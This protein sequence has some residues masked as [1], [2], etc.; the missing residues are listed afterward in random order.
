MERKN[1]N[2]HAAMTMITTVFKSGQL[3]AS[4]LQWV[5]T[6]LNAQRSRWCFVVVVTTAICVTSDLL[7]LQDAQS[8]LTASPSSLRAQSCLLQIL[9]S[10]QL[11]S[12]REAKPGAQG[13]V[14]NSSSAPCQYARVE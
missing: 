4:E 10:I 8:P 9:Q 3:A 14:A 6:L 12:M 1:A 13:V 5:L 2:V 11:E 7:G